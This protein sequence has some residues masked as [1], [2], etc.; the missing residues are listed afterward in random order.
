MRFSE[1]NFLVI[2]KESDTYVSEITIKVRVSIP[3]SSKLSS[4][5]EVNFIN[6]LIL[7]IFGG[8]FV[9]LKAFLWT[10]IETTYK[11]QLIH[12]DSKILA[13]I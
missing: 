3:T 10:K 4:R 7:C 13:Y 5:H 8:I 11:D 1:S 6:I 12:G 2:Q 9:Q